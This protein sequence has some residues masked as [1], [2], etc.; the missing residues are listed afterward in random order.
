M[1]KQQ[2][3]RVLEAIA[4][5]MA[6][7]ASARAA[8]SALQTA[9]PYV[10]RNVVMGGGG[11]VTG[12][13]PHP[14]QK[15]LMY[16]RTDV[17][18][19]Y[20]WDDAAQQWI[21]LTDWI[22]AQDANLTGI[23]SIALNPN[24]P[25]RVY[26]AAG[27]YS[28]NK[29]AILRSVD[30]GRTWQRTD[31]PFR[32]GG[33][34]QGRFN[35]ERLVVD[36][37]QGEMLFF[38]TRR[39]GL[40][41]SADRAVTWQKV[42]SFP[43]VGT[44][45]PPAISSESTNVAR[46]RWERGY[47]FNQ[48]V[49]VVAVV[50]DPA[51]GKRGSPTPRLFAAVSTPGTN[52]FCSSDGGSTWA[53]VPNQ[54]LRLRPNHLVLS[55]DG[56]IY[57]SYGR[58]PG[59]NT[60]TD[61]AVWKYEPMSGAWTDITPAKPKESGQPFGYGCVAVDAQHPQ[62]LMA[63]TFCHWKPHD[64]IFRST[65]GGLTWTQLWETNKIFWDH[66]SAPYAKTRSPHWMGTIAINPF[67]SDQVMFT[68][69]Y[70]I[71][72]CT[73][74]TAADSGKPTQWVFFNH[75]LEETVPLALLSPP[76]G[77]HL[78]TGVGDIDGFRHDD[79]DVSPADGTFAGPRLSTTRDMAFAA[80]KPETIVRIGNA[81]REVSVHINISEDGGKSWSALAG[82]PPGGGNG[83]G[84]LA[85]GADGKT[86]VWLLQSGTAYVTTNRGES[87]TNCAGIESAAEIA[88]DPVDASRFYAH[89]ASVGDL[90][91]STNAALTFETTLATFPNTDA[92]G[93]SGG[94]LA[95][96]PGLSGNLWIGS[97]NIGLFH[98]TNGGVSF[99]KLEGVGGADALGFG[100]AA[101]GQAFPA[102]YL[103]GRVNQLKA[104]YRS[105]DAGKTWIR[106]NDDQ[107]QFGAPDRPMV[108]GDPRIFGRVYLTTGGRG[109]IY[110]DPA[111]TAR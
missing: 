111:T 51:S 48:P 110:G 57:L 8:E 100:K 37:N 15:G 95:V 39:D 27:T 59:P 40:W 22:S 20:R 79:L 24:D 91:I 69:G 109:V 70:G 97:R 61:G 33:N 4:I 72:S 41:K 52:F 66:S 32:T 102:L 105:D 43:E 17:G 28:G 77:A 2:I 84:R 16:A 9:E 35:G 88:A 25:Q 98:S 107:H 6:F 76:T 78:L 74:A 81:D 13:I 11:F 21:P 90:L 30:Q 3:L 12:I 29:A 26:L 47:G 60:M 18:G 73:N 34:E 55:P 67:N 103:L 68:T 96:T 89:D 7:H 108:I 99:T 85:V 94:V 31:V 86:I 53:A 80:G 54:P 106:I 92:G 46:R 10:W 101:P 5:V 82:D 58:E 1:M 62:T 23:E 93:R 71:W 75:G 45:A 50:F 56:T 38:G 65:N 36:P 44:N 42:D 19:A 49:G 87:W 64:Q 14:R 104:Y 63:T 83:Q